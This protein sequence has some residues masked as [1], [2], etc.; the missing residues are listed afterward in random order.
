MPLIFIDLRSSS[1][2]ARSAF[3]SYFIGN[4]LHLLTPKQICNNIPWQERY[5]SSFVFVVPVTSRTSVAHGH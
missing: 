2:L 3:R 4:Y 5:G 1:G